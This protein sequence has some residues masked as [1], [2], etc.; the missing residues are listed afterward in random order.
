MSLVTIIISS[1]L[2]LGFVVYVSS[3]YLIKKH[4]LLEN[5]NGI[6]PIVLLLVVIIVVLL[7]PYI[8]Y[9]TISNAIKENNARRRS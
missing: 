6:P 2:T 5:Q 1:Y 8:L 9:T 3:Y 4:N 7:W